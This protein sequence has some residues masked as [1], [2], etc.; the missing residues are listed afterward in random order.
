[1]N[2]EFMTMEMAK[3]Y[4]N[5]GHYQEALDIYQSLADLNDHDSGAKIREAIARVEAA[6][7][8]PPKAVVNESDPGKR[9]QDL[10]EQW[11]RLLILKK[12]LGLFRKIKARF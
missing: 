9:I 2:Q 11:L 8:N 3:V 12:R 1:M 4:E 5:Q 10:L 7:A 6:Q